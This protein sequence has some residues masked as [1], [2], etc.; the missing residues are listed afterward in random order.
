MNFQQVFDFL[1]RL[2]ANNHKDWMNMHRDEYHSI[3]QDLYDWLMDIDEKLIDI[4][5]DY[6][7]IE[8]K[9]VI[10]RINNNLLYHPNKPV[11]KDH[12]GMGLDQKPG[13]SDFYIHIGI[14]ECFLAG[15]FYKPKTTNLK[16]IR[17]AIDYDG[18]KLKQIM[19]E[20]NFKENFNG[21]M[22]EDR[23]TNAPKGFDKDHPHIDLLKNKSFAV[24]KTI[25]KET[26]L[27]LDLKDEIIKCYKV[28]LPFRKYLNQAISV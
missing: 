22:V 18:E 9:K 10:N 15:G 3:K 11:Y 14:N 13:K 1:E 26:V 21:L 7:P 20:P 23:L 25:D 16:S 17:D 28:L 12:F 8:S 24:Q 5:P 6:Y 2:N 4:D 19:N 27:S